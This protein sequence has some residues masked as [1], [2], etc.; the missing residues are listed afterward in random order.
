MSL[1]PVQSSRRSETS[2]ARPRVWLSGGP[3]GNEQLTAATGVLL[4]ILLA[5]LGVTIL[6]LG[7]LLWEHLF[8]GLLLLGPVALKMASTGYR[9][10]RYYTHDREYMRRGP[11]EMWLR[12][13]APGVVTMTVAVFAT[14]VVLLF[15]GPAQ[16]DPWLLLHKATFILWIAATALHVLGHLFEMPA[17]LRG[18]QPGRRGAQRPAVGRRRPGPGPGR[19]GRGRRGPGDRPHP[20]LQHLDRP[21]GLHDHHGG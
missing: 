19:G 8:L 20:R 5:A 21:L 6:F 15:V 14:G 17:A 12:L 3:D 11:P 1:S 13:L 16:R 9:F 7:R 10:V 4:L 18:A 2:G